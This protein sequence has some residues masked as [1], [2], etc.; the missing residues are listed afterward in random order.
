[1]MASAVARDS[2][3]A[4]AYDHLV[5]GHVRFGRRESARD[6][7]ELRRRVGQ[8]ERQDDLDMLRFLDLAYDERFV[9]WRAWLRYRYVAWRRDP[10][11]LEGIGRI[12]RLGTPWLDMPKTQLRYCDLLL[13][14][15]PV[16]PETHASAHQGKGMALFALGRTREALAELDSAAV[17]FD[18]PEALLQQA[19]WRAIPAAVGYPGLDPR[20]WIQPLA[21]LAH[22]STIGARA[23]WALALLAGSDTARARRWM[24]R[25]PADSP[26]HAMIEARLAAAG[27]D[28]R[29]ALALTDSVRTAFQQSAPPDPFAVAVFHLLRGDWLAAL[30]QP[31]RADREWLWYEASDVE[32]WPQGLAQAGEVGAALGPAARLKR[33][34]ALLQAG[35]SAADT[36][37]ACTL[38][39]RVR[40]LWSAADSSLRPLAAAAALDGACR[41]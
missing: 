22:D 17:L 13:R 26:L 19:E 28:L 6:A 35:T 3:L 36:L 41:A 18:S 31:D 25:L 7:L 16:R 33:A 27:G 4:L 20:P 39:G 9:P 8:A 15:T 2:S 23:A 21:D 12:A 5:L 14:A 10:R 40:E 30:G 38:V 24:D 32:G 1:V 29:A 37:S 11:E 34:R